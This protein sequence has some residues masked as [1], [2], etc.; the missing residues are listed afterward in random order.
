MSSSDGGVGQSV[1]DT[2]ESVSCVDAGTCAGGVWVNVTPSSLPSS[3]LVPS[4][5]AYGPGAVIVNPAL[6]SDLYIGAAAGLWQSTDY[7]MTWA[8]INDSLPAPPMG[9]TIAVAGTSPATIWAADS[10]GS[11]WRSTDGG[12]T[13]VHTGGPLAASLYSLQVDPNDPTHLLSGLHEVDGIVES[14]DSGDTWT[15]VGGSGFPTGAI[16]WFPYFVN[17]GDP[18]TTSQTWIAIPQNG[19]S[20]AI[21]SNSGASW[22]VPAGVEGLQ[23]PVGSTQIYQNG[24]N[25]FA[26]GGQAIYRS[27]DLGANWTMVE[28]GTAEAIVWGTPRSLYA[29][30]SFACSPCSGGS[31]FMASAQPGTAW[32]PVSAPAAIPIGPLDVAVTYDGSHYIAVGVF[33]GYG[34]WRYVEP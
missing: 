34:I 16:S 31:N 20:V 9:V 3:V 23:H 11:I 33:W 15:V 6:S 24:S 8:Q 29:M 7:G 4:P 27:T 5:K 14:T 2:G 32:S 17:T 21:T 30:W 10:D 28:S 1:P 18:T 19:G 13:F 22:T 12:S 26:G 25:F